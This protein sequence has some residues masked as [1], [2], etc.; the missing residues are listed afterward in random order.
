MKPRRGLDRA[1]WAARLAAE[2][3][4]ADLADRLASYLEL[5]GRWGGAVDLF[6]GADP[7]G[8]LT[9]LVRD[10]LAA[11]PHLGETDTLIDIGSGNGF[12]AIPLL[13]A[14][15]GVRGILLEPRER[16]WAFLKEAARE[17]GLAA[18]VRRERVAEHAGGGYDV[19]TVRGVG[20]ETWLPDASRLVKAGGRWLW[21][22]SAANAAALAGRVAEGRVLP[23]P[24]SDPAHGVLAVWRRCS[25]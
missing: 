2:G 9:S 13:V 3:V 10:A 23:F 14:R 4:P 25:T 20:F 16:R 1:S 19:A 17:L 11:L 5:L 8:L 22:T 6:G 24:L 12:P 21:W 18:D 7:G 15:P